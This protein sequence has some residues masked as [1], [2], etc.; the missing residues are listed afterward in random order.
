MKKTIAVL[1]ATLFGLIVMAQPPVPGKRGHFGPDKANRGRM[2]KGA[3]LKQIEL[4]DAQKTEWK[5]IQKAHWQARK[6]LME[7]EQITV[8]E[9]RDKLFDLSKAHQKQIDALLTPAQREQLKAAMNL[10]KAK[11]EAK[12]AQ[13][14]ERMSTRLK[15]TVAQQEAM[16]Q[17]QVK[18]KSTIE[19]VKADRNADR[20]ALQLKMKQAMDNHKKAIAGILT[21]EQKKEMESIKANMPGPDGPK[22]PHGGRR[23]KRMHMEAP[24]R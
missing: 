10:Q 4:T 11:M 2:E 14:F 7:N 5:K 1:T 8:K 23:G 15:L 16:K 9:Q 6:A 3:L 22:G 13:G 18:M 12:R 19:A 24:T 21:E 17:E 20:S